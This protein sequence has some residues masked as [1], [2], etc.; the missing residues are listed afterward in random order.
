MEFEGNESWG[1]NP[2]FFFAP[3]K[4]YG[5]AN[6]LKMLI[7]SCHRR[8][9]AVVLDIAL[10]HAFGQ[11]PMVRL[12]FDPQAGDFGQPTPESPWFNPVPKHDF[13]VG[14]DFNHESPATRYFSKRAIAHWV[15]EYK[16]DGYRFDLSKGFTQRNTLGNIGAWNAFDQSRVDIWE[17]YRNHLWAI[18]SNLYLILEHFADNSEERV[19]SDMGF[20]L[21]G[22]A[23]HEYNEAT[24][25]FSSNLSVAGHS[26][27]SWNDMNLVGYKESHDE[28]RLQFKNNRFGRVTSGYNVRDPE[29]GL[30][31]IEAAANILYAIPGPKMLWQFGEMGYDYSI[32]HC[33]DGTI[34]EGC[35]T[36][37]KPIRWDYMTEPARIQLFGAFQRMIRLHT[38]HPI[39]KSPVYEM[40]AHPFLK[41]VT[42]TGDSATYLIA[43]ANFDFRDGLISPNWPAAGMWYEYHSGDSLEVDNLTDEIFLLKG[44]YRL[45]TNFKIELN[46]DTTST[47]PGEDPIEPGNFTRVGPNPFSGA[48]LFRLG[49]LSTD[50][51]VINIYNTQG[52]IIWRRVINALNNEVRTIEWRGTTTSGSP[53]GDGIYYYEVQRRN[54][55]IKGKLFK[56]TP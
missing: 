44:A 13:N 52:Q 35:R 32:N 10:N 29:I 11:N 25:A 34:Q 38:Q 27:R 45:Y 55:N 50:Q 21:W 49:T 12:Y 9:I 40:N 22:N 4:Y 16:I 46:P 24:M 28:E 15:E 2:M 48:V 14:F 53:V 31:R 26:N 33:P 41:R 5:P 37:N 54:E 56:V 43:L 42:V 36:S 1:Y 47:D 18:D 7:D 51:A 39:F 3:D 8:G 20:M 6:D 17:D 30:A 19:L 23:N